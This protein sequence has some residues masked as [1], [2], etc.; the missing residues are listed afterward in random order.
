MRYP[1]DGPQKK[2]GVRMLA[3]T[4][5]QGNTFGLSVLPLSRGAVSPPTAPNGTL[6]ATRGE[7]S[8]FRGAPISVEG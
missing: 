7:E 5:A 6:A 1:Q 8:A 4:T 2:G 3:L